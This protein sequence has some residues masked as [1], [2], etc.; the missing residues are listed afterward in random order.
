MAR[1]RLQV[2][3]AEEVKANA[4]SEELQQKEALKSLGA[5]LE[6][7]KAQLGALQNR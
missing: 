4:E 1:Y 2:E 7:A 6:A 5:E 3:R